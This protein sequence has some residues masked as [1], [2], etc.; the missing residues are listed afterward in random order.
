[1]CSPPIIKSNAVKDEGNG[2]YKIINHAWVIFQ[3]YVYSKIGYSIKCSSYIEREWTDMERK[4]WY[5]TSSIDVIVFW[6][7]PCVTLCFILHR[8]AKYIYLW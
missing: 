1:M 8:Y 6:S 4:L 2:V 5:N 7:F 3:E